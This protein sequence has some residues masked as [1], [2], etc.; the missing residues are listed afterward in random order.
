MKGVSRNLRWKL[1]LG[2]KAQ[3]QKARGARILV[4]HG[5]CINHPLRYNTLFLS[6][7]IFEEHLK[8]FKKYFH[9]VSLDE[10]YRQEFSQD[11]FNIC[12][13]FDDGFANNHR[14]VLPLLEKYSVPASFFI[15]GIREAGYDILWNDLLAIAYRY[16]P[17]RFSFLD[18]EISRGPGGKYILAATGELLATMLRST[19]FVEK[20]ALINC[21]DPE[22]R[23]RRS[24]QED[25]WLQM[26][27]E[28]IRELAANPL[29]TIG[30]HGYYHND[31]SMIDSELMRKEL[32]DSKRFLESLTGKEV[33]SLAF[34]YG[35]YSDN[36]V[37]TARECGYKQLLATGFNA[38]SDAQTP[39][40]KERFTV[41]PFISTVNQMHANLS[42]DY[43][44]A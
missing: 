8:F 36:V 17:K 20:K 19:S 14:Y 16:G 7:N 39:E 9:V 6:R 37:D 44:H 41:N 25:F 43:K 35:S 18:Q 40:L 24:A 13:S 21:L 10:F 30:S 29:V 33:R 12:I 28:Q 4:Y 31:L 3:F 26:S 23:L 42:G 11:R 38:S 15:T 22:G 1:G 32:T 5:I 27:V 2:G 34:P